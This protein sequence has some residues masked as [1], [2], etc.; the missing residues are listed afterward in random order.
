M[1]L[2]SSACAFHREA[3]LTSKSLIDRPLTPRELDVLRLVADGVGNT[4]IADRLQMGLGTVK[5]HLRD[6]LNKLAAS[7]RAQAVAHALRRG[8]ID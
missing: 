8:Y 5:G 2:P 3:Q 7:D 1:T 4:E 6:I